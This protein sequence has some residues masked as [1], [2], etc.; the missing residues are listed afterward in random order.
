MC[1]TFHK[2]P[3]NI[4]FKDGEESEHGLQ[5]VMRTSK[6]DTYSLGPSSRLDD[7]NG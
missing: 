5:I 2:E 4:S 1:P 6:E 7:I 3:G